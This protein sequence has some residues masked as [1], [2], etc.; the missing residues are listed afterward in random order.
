MLLLVELLLH[1]ATI[2]FSLL[3]DSIYGGNFCEV[4]FCV[5][6]SGHLHY[7]LR[8]VDREFFVSI[9]IAEPFDLRLLIKDFAMILADVIL[10][11][12]VD[13]LFELKFLELQLRCVQE[14]FIFRN[15]IVFNF[16]QL[17]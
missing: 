3:N 1:K 15:D 13:L 9:Q 8:V 7:Y 12:D 4:L 17:D 5:R 11:L 14:F 2:L 6:S 10:N 16:E